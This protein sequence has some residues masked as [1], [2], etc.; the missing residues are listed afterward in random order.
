MRN[1]IFVVAALVCSLAFYGCVSSGPAPQDVPL[2][3]LDGRAVIIKDIYSLPTIENK[4]LKDT[5]IIKVFFPQADN[6]RMKCSITLLKIPS[7]ISPPKYKQTSSQIIYA[8]SGGGKLEIGSNMIVLKKGIMVYVPPN[9]AMTITNNVNQILEIIVVTSPPFDASQITMLEEGP[10]KVKVSKDSEDTANDNKVESQSLSEKYK[11][12]K[13][14]KGRKLSVKEY[15]NR[16]SKELFPET[17]DEKDS[18]S[19]LL[20]EDLKDKPKIKKGSWPLKMPDGSKVPL[21]ELE[22]EQREKLIPKNPQ[23]IE[24]VSLKDIQDLTPKEQQVPVRSESTKSKVNDKSSE[25]DQD[26]LEKLLKDQEELEKKTTPKPTAPKQIAPKEKA[27]AE[28]I[29][30]AKNIKKVSK[31][32][33]VSLKNLQEL[34]PAEKAV[35]TKSD[36]KT[37]L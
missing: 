23:K 12:K 4:K 8:I 2:Q 32:N 13:N 29:S 35:P 30:T 15:Q 22:K 17:E 11:D 31:I 6:V 3:N 16:M 20:K 27:P 24:N 18:I 34:S 37:D 7:G 28:T 26:S 1:I 9:T 36:T 14:R 5:E 10:T 21:K 19:E 25:N 33:K